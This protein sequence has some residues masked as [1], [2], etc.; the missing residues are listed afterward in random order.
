MLFVF[1]CAKE[2]QPITPPQAQV[3][4]EPQPKADGQ[5]ISVTLPCKCGDLLVYVPGSCPCFDKTIAPELSPTLD[6]VYAWTKVNNNGGGKKI[7]GKY[8]IIEEECG[9]K[10]QVFV[11]G[12]SGCL[13]KQYPDL[14]NLL[15]SVYET[16]KKHEEKNK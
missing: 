7:V 2:N 8:E 3:L 16:A 1:G 14:A 13:A 15:N 11:P 5:Y 10:I 9:C 6:N 12:S 4:Q